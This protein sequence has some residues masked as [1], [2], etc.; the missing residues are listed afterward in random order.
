MTLTWWDAALVG[1]VSAQ[2]AIIAY[3]RQPVWKAFV[4]TLP[5]PFTMA[6]L[7]IARRVDATNVVGLLFLVGFVNLVRWLH[8]SLGVRIVP[9]IA[10]GAGLHVAVSAVVA[11]G[12]PATD[13]AFYASTAGVVL[14]AGTIYLLTP[15]VREPGHRTSLPVYVKVPA[16][17]ALVGVLVMVKGLLLGFMTTFPM[18]TI[19][20]LY[21]ARHSLSTLCRQMA[22]F[23]LAFVPMMIVCRLTEP[24]V[25]QGAA[26]LLGWPLYLAIW[27]P[28]SLRSSLAVRSAGAEPSLA[29]SVPDGEG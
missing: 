2:A 7:A 5:L 29:D 20:A 15:T 16:I 9:A 10:A 3:I 18:V 25:G 24:R 17:A 19:F 28:V 23:V 8:R 21:E 4:L 22:G 11:P 13:W 12:I 1:T 27:L 26:V 6:S 14:V